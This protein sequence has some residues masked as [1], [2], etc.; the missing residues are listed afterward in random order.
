METPVSPK[1]TTATAAG[2]LVSIL[3]WL[4][5]YFNIEVPPEVSAALVVLIMAIAAWAQRDGLRDAGQAAITAPP[6]T[7]VGEIPAV[8]DQR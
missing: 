7:P 3:V 2:A 5:G 4:V 1:V 8:A 6:Q